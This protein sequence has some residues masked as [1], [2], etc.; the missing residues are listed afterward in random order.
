[1]ATS[2]SSQPLMSGARP[3][4]YAGQQQDQ[5]L[6][7][8][9]VYTGP[10]RDTGSSPSLTLPPKQ[11]LFIKDGTVQGDAATVG[12]AHLSYL[13]RAWEVNACDLTNVDQAGVRVW[14]QRT[15]YEAPVMW[16]GRGGPFLLAV[17]NVLLIVASFYLLTELFH[18]Q[19]TSAVPLSLF[20]SHLSSWVL[21]LSTSK[22]VLYRSYSIDDGLN[23][24]TRFTLKLSVPDSP[25]GTTFIQ[26][27]CPSSISS[28]VSTRGST[29][30]KLMI[31]VGF[32]LGLGL[33]IKFMAVPIR[34]WITDMTAF[35]YV[36]IILTSFYENR[37]FELQSLLDHDGHPLDIH[38]QLLDTAALRRETVQPLKEQVQKPKPTYSHFHIVGVGCFIGVPFLGYLLTFNEQPLSFFLSLGGVLCGAAFFKLDAL[39]H[40]EEQNSWFNSRA[41]KATNVKRAL[42]CIGIEL[43]CLTLASVAGI[44]YQPRT[45]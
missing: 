37:T 9:A 40:Q 36:F 27:N 17:F 2:T 25:D 22:L 26:S 1:M 5:E 14:P 29:L 35:G 20:I 18:V 32:S 15:T 45:G 8:K 12:E 4:P 7:K 30:N 39:L 21:V 24:I 33:F 41:S 3:Q 11:L 10:C 13:C 19:V 16:L 34:T 38:D 6:A 44:C 31:G 23:T 28:T 42:A 43:A